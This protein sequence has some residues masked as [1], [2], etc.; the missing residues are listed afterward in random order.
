MM[1]TL[2]HKYTLNV[3]LKDGLKSKGFSPIKFEA[4]TGKVEKAHKQCKA[5]HCRK[6]ATKRIITSKGD[7]IPTCDTCLDD[8]VKELEE[9][10]E[11][12]Y[13]ISIKAD[14]ADDEEDEDT[15]Y[16]QKNKEDAPNYKKSNSDVFICENCVF[17]SEINT[18]KGDI[19]YCSIYDFEFTK[20][21]VCDSYTPKDVEGYS[22]YAPFTTRK[23]I[24]EIRELRRW[25][26]LGD[27][28]NELEKAIS[29]AVLELVEPEPE[30][31]TK[32]WVIKQINE[33]E[34][35]VEGIVMVP[36]KED[37][38]K[39]TISGEEIRKTAI[40]FMLKYQDI[41]IMHSKSNDDLAEGLSVVG[42][43]VLPT[44]S[45]YFG[46]GVVLAKDTWILK[47]HVNNPE[48]WKLVKAGKLKGFSIEG[49]GTRTAI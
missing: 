28:R 35:T 14:H 27:S 49:K 2:Y 30:D 22:V 42:N 3:K 1:D 17:A 32:T 48:T 10:N 18:K 38:Q 12:L 25:R 11:K 26:E 37:L 20:G 44:D 41:N 8:M 40:N 16:I 34:H 45:D 39:D 46:D 24:D 9:D 21:W 47:V 33:E 6:V 13:I 36:E 29:D 43:T 31:I 5:K 15:M 4:A 19:L 23:P 7:I